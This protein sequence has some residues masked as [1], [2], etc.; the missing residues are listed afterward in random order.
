MFKFVVQRLLQAI[1]VVLIAS[2]LVFAL[3]RFL[4]GDPA[5]AILGNDARIEDIERLRAKMGLDKPIYVQYAV[6]LGQVLQGDMGESVRNRYPVGK[7][8]LL[9]ARAT[10]ELAVGGMLVATLIAFPLGIF[11]ALKR[12]AFAERVITVFTSAFYAIPTFWL[13]ILL[14]TLVA[15]QWRLVPPSGRVDPSVNFGN[16]IKLLILPS[17]TLGVP[18]AAVLAR[19]IKT[20]LLEVMGQ[21]Y[22]RTA[23]SKGLRSNI[24]VLRHALRNAM[25][26]VV[27]VFSLQFGAF[28][29]GSVV[30]ESIY[31]W[32]GLGSLA[33]QGILTRDYPVVQGTILFVVVIFIFMNLLAD[34]SYGLLNPRIR[35]SE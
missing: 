24:I 14:V 12:G 1:P 20:S 3:V 34:I 4:P 15:L 19:F 35:Y 31:D 27:T 16:F 5:Y 2:I 21:D 23:R 22:I 29:G 11:S 25:L 18:T 10:V 33:L 28:L 13:G 9:K 6:W 17:I 7:L 8:I 30:T 26:P 32:P